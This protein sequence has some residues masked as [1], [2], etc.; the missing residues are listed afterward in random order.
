MLI[1]KNLTGA[2]TILLALFPLVEVKDE[3]KRM[4]NSKKKSTKSNQKLIFKQNKKKS[5]SFF[6]GK[7]VFKNTKNDHFW[8]VFLRQV[9]LFFRMHWIFT[10]FLKFAIFP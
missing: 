4:Q 8:S 1:M 10:S 9:L 2:S 5:D 6:M 3:T 7:K